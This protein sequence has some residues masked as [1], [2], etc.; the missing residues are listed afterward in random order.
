MQKGTL[1]VIKN[2]TLLT[3]A[4][5]EAVSQI[6]DWITMM[7]IF[8]ILVFKGGGSVVASSGIYLA[9]LLP[10]IPASLMAGWL[11]DRIDRKWLM[12][13]SQIL[14]GLTVAGLIF[15]NRIELVYT[16]VALQAIFVAVMGPARMAVI[17]QIIS[18]EDLPNANAFFQQLS[19]IIKISAPVLAGALLAVMEPHQ[20]IILDVISFAIAAFMLTFIPSLPPVRQKAETS[21]ASETVSH[22]AS[23][24]TENLWKIFKSLPALQLVFISIFFGIL[25][26]IGYD[27][28]SSIYIRDILHGGESLYGLAI[29]LV[30]IG[31]LIT[32]IRVMSRKQAGSPWWDLVKG[33]G[34]LGIIPFTMVIAAL[35]IG[36]FWSKAIVLA[37]CLVGGYGNGLINIQVATLL[38]T[39]TPPQVMGRMSGVF[40]SMLTVG[41]LIGIVL[42]PLMVPAVLSIE[43]YFA[44]SAVGMI[45]LVVYLVVQL[46]GRQQALVRQVQAG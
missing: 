32:T 44:A 5:A 46:N 8:A 26:I 35:P 34:L 25:V 33:L 9:G 15:T 37:G 23:A 38:Q 29:S 3:I 2:K 1:Q 7:A 22:P 39:T 19:S 30:G 13:A 31:T 45:A 10:N 41:Q 27:V 12:I 4:L 14:S 20:A 18:T 24:P 42:T 36:A 40:H 21:P 17:P 6:G 16:L 28:L 43:G 11:V